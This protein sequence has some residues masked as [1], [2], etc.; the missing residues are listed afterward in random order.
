MMNSFVNIKNDVSLFLFAE[1]KMIE[2]DDCKSV[3]TR[4]MQAYKIKKAKELADQWD[5][6]AS[7]IS[8]RIQRNSLPADFVLRCTLDTGANIVWL[9]TGQG[10]PG[11]DGVNVIKKLILSDDV[12]EKLERLN[13]LKEKGGITEQEYNILKANLI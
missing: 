4:I 11:V 6:A 5:I 1:N 9:C 10:E 8:S 2:F 7:V 13:A 3:V 12:L